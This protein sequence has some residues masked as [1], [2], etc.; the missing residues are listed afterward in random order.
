MR[1][2]LN[3]HICLEKKMVNKRRTA[4]RGDTR[5]PDGPDGI[6][7]TGFQVQSP[8]EKMRFEGGIIN[9][10]CFSWRLSVASYFPIPTRELIK[11]KANGFELTEGVWEQVDYY[12]E[13]P[14][15]EFNYSQCIWIYVVDIELPQG[16]NEHF[17]NTH[18]KQVSEG[19]QLSVGEQ[20]FLRNLWFADEAAVDEINPKNIM[21]AVKCERR[22]NDAR[23]WKE[24]GKYQLSGLII[25][26]RAVSQDIETVKQIQKFL[27]Q[28]IASQENAAWYTMPIGE[29]GYK[30]NEPAAISELPLY[31][32]FKPD[33][34][35][36]NLDVDK[37]I[38]SVEP[39]K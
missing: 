17:M 3:I 27:E 39:K 5:K 37:E 2:Y 7:S 26:P 33:A 38:K 31:T 20:A 4:F 16:E 23:D 25:N 10:V 19:A 8:E 24:G 30:K 9:G 13:R 36:P 32:F 29:E 35:A 22:F 21:F 14:K 28:E 6:F 15:Y 1:L 18:R 34:D 12:P 11:C